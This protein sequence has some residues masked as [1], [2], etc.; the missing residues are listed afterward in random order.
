MACDIC[1]GRGRIELPIRGRMPARYDDT[2]PVLTVPRLATTKDARV[3]ALR[4]ARMPLQ[5]SDP[6]L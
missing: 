6:V 1:G 3:L 2:T 5:A 4:R